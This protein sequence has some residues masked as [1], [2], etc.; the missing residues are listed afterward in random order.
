MKNKM[1]A[2]LL[3][4]AMMAITTACGA[5][6]STQSQTV[7]ADQESTETETRQQATEEPEDQNEEEQTEEEPTQEDQATE[8]PEEQTEA[9]DPFTQFKDELTNRGIDYETV[10]T[11]AEM[12]GAEQGMKFKI[13]EGTVEL[14][15]F[16][17]E[18][19]AYTKAEETQSIYL[20]G[21]GAFPATVK[22]SLA[23]TI[24]DL[25]EDDYMEIFS[26]IT[27]N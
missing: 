4:C 15:R 21:F 14:Y 18:S 24:S 19:D 27:G 5:E 13:G 12:I 23:M 10:V 22:D 2:T 16:D 9:A 1:I 20:E 17:T 8:E 6:T 25:E 26:D 3:I 7:K 11:A